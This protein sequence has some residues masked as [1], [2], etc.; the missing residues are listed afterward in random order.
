MVLFFLFACAT[1]QAPEVVSGD[2]QVAIPASA[3]A[4]VPGQLE[5][6][7]TKDFGGVRAVF[8]GETLPEGLDAR[9]GIREIRFEINGK[10]EAFKPTGT[11][12]DSDWS[13]E[14]ATAEGDWIVLPQDHYG[15]YHVISTARLGEYLEAGKADYELHQQASVENAGAWVHAD[16]R[17]EGR[18]LVYRAGLTD[19]MEFRFEL[20]D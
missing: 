15:P 4:V 2:N 12:Q 8:L 19:M 18:A 5:V 6:L 11:L 20:S 14:I 9:F 3:E 7:A 1:T 16:A 10:A 17:W 13:F